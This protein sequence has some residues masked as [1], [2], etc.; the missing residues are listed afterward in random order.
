MPR[1]PL[2]LQAALREAVAA[3]FGQP[4]RYPSH[5]DALELELQQNA[6]TGGRRLSPSTLRRFFGLVDKD[7]G[8][9]MH[10]LDTLARYAGHADFAAF[11]QAVSGLA[12]QDATAPGPAADIP[13][14]LAES[15]FFVSSSLTEGVSLTLLEAM[16]V[17]LPVVATA[18]GGNPEVVVDGLTGRLVP[19]KVRSIW[20]LAIVA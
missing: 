9:H 3:R 17:G 18:V 4:L 10:T 6:A 13:E 1:L 14:L 12:M 11:G 20:S 15:G 16:A 19:A 5:C 8:Y 7:G 2:P